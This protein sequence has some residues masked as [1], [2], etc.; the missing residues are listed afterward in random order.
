MLEYRTSLTL[1]LLLFGIVIMML[2]IPASGQSSKP[3][4]VDTSLTSVQVGKG[5][6]GVAVD[7][8]THRVYVTNRIPIRY[9]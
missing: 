5:P 6:Y 4:K 2:C 1:G 3:D 8:D 7:N 9:Q